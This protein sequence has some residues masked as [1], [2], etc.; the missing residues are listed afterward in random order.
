MKKVPHHVVDQLHSLLMDDDQFQE[1]LMR[2][3]LEVAAGVTDNT[4]DQM[5]L[6]MEL[7]TRVSVS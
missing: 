3:A 1:A 4:E 5:D 7:T 6:A 2:V